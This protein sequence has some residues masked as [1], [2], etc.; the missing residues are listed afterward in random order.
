MDMSEPTLDS[1]ASYLR[2]LISSIHDLGEFASFI[3][4]DDDE[5]AGALLCSLQTLQIILESWANSFP[6]APPQAPWIPDVFPADDMDTTLYSDMYPWTSS[7]FTNVTTAP[8]PFSPSSSS[9]ELSSLSL[10]SSLS[11]V[12]LSSFGAT[13]SSS[14]G[15]NISIT[16]DKEC[17]LGD[18]LSV[19]HKFPL[20]IP[21]PLAIHG[22][23]FHRYISAVGEQ[24]ECHQESP[25]SNYWSSSTLQS[26]SQESQQCLHSDQSTIQSSDASGGGLLRFLESQSPNDGSWNVVHIND[27]PKLSWNSVNIADRDL[28]E[29]HYHGVKYQLEYGENIGRFARLLIDDDVFEFQS[30]P[31]DADKRPTD[32]MCV[33]FLESFAL[34]AS[35]QGSVPYLFGPPFDGRWSDYVDSGERLKSQMPPDTKGITVPYWYL[36][37]KF[38]GTVFHKADCDL[39]SMSL[40]IHGYKLWLIIDTRDTKKFEQWVRHVWG[41]DAAQ[42]DQ[43]IRHLGLILPPSMLT[44]AGFRFNLI[45]AGPGDLIVTSPDQYHYVVSMTTSLAIAVNFLFPGEIIAREKTT[46]CEDCGLY[47]LAGHV[48]N[49]FAVSDQTANKSCKRSPVQLNPARP[50]KRCQRMK[51]PRSDGYNTNIS[52]VDR[53]AEVIKMLQAP[54]ASCFAPIIAETSQ[55]SSKIV[56]LAMAM[57]GRSAIAQMWQLQQ[58]GQNDRFSDLREALI[59]RSLYGN[60]QQVALDKGIVICNRANQQSNLLRRL[61]IWHFAEE[62]ECSKSPTAIRVSS[63]VVSQ[64]TGE[65]PKSRYNKLKYRGDLLHMVCGFHRGLLPFIPLQKD[66]ACG[67][68][69]PE[70]QYQYS[71]TKKEFKD[72]EKLFQVND[73][74]TSVLCAIGTSFLDSWGYK[75][76]CNFKYDTW[77]QKLH[78]DFNE[79]T[80]ESLSKSLGEGVCGCSKNDPRGRLYRAL[81]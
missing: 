80:V 9:S 13:A 79:Q 58:A 55:P 61:L 32:Q 5:A 33:Q 24:E 77:L 28:T 73:A 65:S 76:P 40:V 37:G 1:Y 50:R 39:R 17:Q 8:P 20:C 56:H 12:T 70:S 81:P 44:A 26:T 75:N 22:S 27:L 72:F 36:G 15:Y 67:I 60:T 51:A 42:D 66:D 54:P 52:E 2:T 49:L 47:P 23:E 30:L 64:Y 35:L 38:S 71:A 29:Y 16:T 53:C 3:V 78:Q 21:E 11:K 46:L 31:N 62:V 63:A 6:V 48:P 59:D 68:R 74:L 7:L 4:P 57:R 43:W 25:S 45:C 18:D 14:D 19:V 10:F 69:D 41:K 34:E